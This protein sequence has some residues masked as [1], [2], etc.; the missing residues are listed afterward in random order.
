MCAIAMRSAQIRQLYAEGKVGKGLTF[1]GL[2][3]T[4]GDLIS[5]AGGTAQDVAAV[6]GHSTVAQAEHYSRGADRKK[7]ARSAMRRLERI[8]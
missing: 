1:H 4:V 5:E 8:M 2:R 7:R 6:L 3:H